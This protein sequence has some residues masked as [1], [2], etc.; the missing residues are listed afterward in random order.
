[1]IKRPYLNVDVG[2]L[3]SRIGVGT[4]IIAFPNP[5]YIATIAAANTQ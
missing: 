3:H 5:N 4:K 2:D 1:M